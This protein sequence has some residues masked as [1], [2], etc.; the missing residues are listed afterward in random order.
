MSI[1]TPQNPILSKVYF[2]IIEPLLRRSHL[3]KPLTWDNVLK[4]NSPLMLYAGGLTPELPQYSTHIGLTP[5]YYSTKSIH[6]DI[7]QPMLIEKEMVD[8]YQAEDVFEHIQYEQIP[9]I[10]NEI[11]R[12]LKNDGLFRFSVPDYRCNIH[13]DRSVKNKKGEIV[14]DP[15]GGGSFVNE[16]VINGGHV[17]FPTIELVK[18]LFNQSKFKENGE[19]QY[20]HFYD[21]A[22][23]GITQNIDYKYGYIARTPDHDKRA[24]SPFR[25]ISIVVDA[26]KKRLN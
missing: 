13:R 26:Y 7:V 6:H 14:F 3:L 22:G 25:P 1:H 17:W 20:L 11:F 21:K 8:I 2:K 23:K 24:Q 5:F 9:A 10:F 16:E 12:V 18:Y 19:I 4:N 15:E